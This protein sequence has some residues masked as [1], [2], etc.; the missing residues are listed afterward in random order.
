MGRV[1]RSTLPSSS[2]VLRPSVSTNV[3]VTLQ[4]LQR[5]QRTFCN[6]DTEKLPEVVSG[7]TV[8]VKTEHGWRP[9][10]ITTTRAEPRSNDIKTSSGQQYR[11]NRK[12][13][14]KTSS[15]IQVYNKQTVLRMNKTALQTLV[16]QRLPVQ[17]LLLILP[18]RRSK[19]EV[20]EPSLPRNWFKDD[21][22]TKHC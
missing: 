11:H 10:V 4:S 21:E 8:H 19:R 18:L 15:D 13:L 16:L 2:T 7:G 5:Q 20:V 3:H 17:S 12:H 14:R 9:A 22:I 6:R 1:L